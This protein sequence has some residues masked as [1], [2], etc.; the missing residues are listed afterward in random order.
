MSPTSD[1]RELFAEERLRPEAPG[2]LV[3]CALLLCGGFALV[4]LAAPTEPQQL[5]LGL[6]M[7]G[8]GLCE[9]AWLYR[10]AAQ[11]AQRLALALLAARATAAAQ[12][13][14]VQ[15][16]EDAQELHLTGSFEL[17]LLSRRVTPSRALWALLFGAPEERG[18]AA[19]EPVEVI[20]LLSAIHPDDRHLLDRIIA[21]DRDTPLR[22]TLRSQLPGGPLRFLDTRLRRG[23][24]RLLGVMQDVSATL[25]DAQGAARAHKEELAAARATLELVLSILRGLRAPLGAA[26]ELAALLGAGAPPT[27]QH[28]LAAL[29]ESATAALLRIDDGLAL[30][31]DEG[32]RRERLHLRALCEAEL[33]RVMDAASAK[34]LC[35][36]LDLPPALEAE[37]LG[38]SRLLGAVLR[39]LLD[40]AVKFT[41]QGGVTLQV[42]EDGPERVQ[43]SVIDSGPGMPAA[44]LPGDAGVGLALCQLLVARLS[45]RLWLQRGSEG[46]CAWHFTARLP[47]REPPP[48]PAREPAVLAPPL[49]IL[50]AEDNPVNAKLAERLLLKLGH[51]VH[52][53]ENGALALRALDQ[54]RYDLVLMDL[55][56]PE[57][58]GISATQVLRAREGKTGT[59]RTPVVA[60]TANCGLPE[61]S[62]CAAAGMDDF[63]P[64]PL[65]PDALI[66]VLRRFSPTAR[67]PGDA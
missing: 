37:R 61:R 22:F 66:E 8:L 45:G 52:H 49:H 6:V 59:A 60:L 18:A 10:Q 2:L 7:L 56:M 15:R 23:A 64:K 57:L 36:A 16:L 34:G 19:A 53:V 1:D 44:P 67:A 9:G 30:A 39:H 65:R 51:A 58:D 55:Q 33:G 41:Q 63:L 43:L 42:G 31:A 32:A 14:E 47:R 29:R 46:G 62:A 21:G 12:Q 40:N 27:A 11:R 35:L 28:R 17:S 24:E 50:L 3:L 5:R 4:A 38:S 13:R 26:Q 25:S 48:E 54:A 20:R